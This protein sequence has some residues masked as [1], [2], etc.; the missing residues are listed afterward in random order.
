MRSDRR[1]AMALVLG[2]LWIAGALA[3]IGWLDGGGYDGLIAWLVASA[4]L[5]PLI[6]LAFWVSRAYEADLAE[7]DSLRERFDREHR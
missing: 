3:L 5:A 1:L 6:A 7:R 2:W 4:V